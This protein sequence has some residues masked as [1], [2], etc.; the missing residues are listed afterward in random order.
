[1]NVL[2]RE[3]GPIVPHG[4]FFQYDPVRLGAGRLDV[5]DV[6]QTLTGGARRVPDLELPAVLR[7][8]VLVGIDRWTRVRAGWEEIIGHNSIYRRVGDN[9]VKPVRLH[10]PHAHSIEAVILGGRYV[11]NGRQVSLE[12]LALGAGN[13]A[14]QQLH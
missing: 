1:M 5:V 12:V 7:V 11:R 6:V 3:R 8:R 4:R 14:P 10:R 9:S 2:I 13:L